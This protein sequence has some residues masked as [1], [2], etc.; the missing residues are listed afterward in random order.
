MC[1]GLPESGLG[2]VGK[3]FSIGSKPLLLRAYDLRL[4]SPLQLGKLLVCMPI[5]IKYLHDIEVGISDPFRAPVNRLGHFT[6]REIPNIAHLSLFYT[7]RSFVPCLACFLHKR[8]LALFTG[9]L[10]LQVMRLAAKIIQKN[11]HSFR[12]FPPHSFS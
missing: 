1:K 7:P 6:V 5:L 11:R 4:G 12:L 9:R 3:K 10:G 8:L 2:I